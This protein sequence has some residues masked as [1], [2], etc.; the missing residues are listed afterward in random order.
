[1]CLFFQ[2]GTQWSSFLPR[3]FGHIIRKFL[4]VE[5]P[6]LNFYQSDISYWSQ[7][8]DYIHIFSNISSNIFFKSKM[9][10]PL[11]KLYIFQFYFA[12]HHIC[13]FFHEYF[14]C[15]WGRFLWTS[16]CISDYVFLIVTIS[17]FLASNMT[18]I[19]VMVLFLFNFFPKFFQSPFYLL[20]IFLIIVFF[21]WLFTS[22]FEGFPPQNYIA[23]YV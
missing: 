18:F 20:S 4:L 6:F 9:L 1:M 16:H 7:N 5:Y 15:V 23:Y 14:G 13:T 11:K 21:L 12:F 22:I 10:F 2:R 8:Q 3:K 17:F 19:S